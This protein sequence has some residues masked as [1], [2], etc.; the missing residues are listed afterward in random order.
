MTHLSAENQM[1]LQLLRCSLWGEPVCMPDAV[2]WERLNS[3]AREQG[4]VSFAYDAAVREGLQPPAEIYGK[5]KIQTLAGVTKSE[6]LLLAQDDIVSWFKEANVPVVVLKGSSVAQIYPQPELRQLGDIDIL[7][8]AEDVGAAQELIE[9]RGYRKCESDHEFHIGYAKPG[10]YL[11]LH[12]NVSNLPNTPGGQAAQKLVDCFLEDTQM[13]AIGAHCFPVLSERNQA[14]SLL[15]HMIRHMFHEGI[16]LRQLCD[17]A[18]YM[19]ST[20]ETVFTESVIPALRYCGLLEYAKVATQ[21]SVRYLG[22]SPK[23]AVWCG[24]VSEETCR[25][26][27]GAI[28]GGGNM[29][30]ADK[31]GMGSLF[32]DHETM[33]DSKDSAWRTLILKTNKLIY[34]QFPFVETAKILLPLFWVFLPVRYLTRSMLGLRPKK[35]VS[36]VVSIAKKKRN[37]YEQLALFEIES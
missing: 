10:V 12:Y 28:F 19:A 8:R 26:F 27:I 25:A 3:V 31:D 21:A 4:V 13:G 34:K 33:G 9:S 30:C 5:W 35:S 22:L 11:E 14:L 1:I 24:D 20:D 23:K 32:T 36:K 18:I 17:W 16:G 7:V 15:L 6:R 29:G 37:L 2:N